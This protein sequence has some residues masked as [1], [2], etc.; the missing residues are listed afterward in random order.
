MMGKE[1]K[2]SEEGRNQDPSE[3]EVQRAREA[4]QKVI[5]TAQ[6]AL[7]GATDPLEICVGDL[8]KRISET[9]EL[10]KEKK[11]VDQGVYALHALTQI[12]D[13]QDETL[14]DRATGRRPDLQRGQIAKL[15]QEIALPSQRGLIGQYI[16][17]NSSLRA[18][19]KPLVVPSRS[20]VE[21]CLKRISKLVDWKSLGKHPSISA[22]GPDAVLHLVAEREPEF[23]LV[24]HQLMEEILA[25]SPPR[26]PLVKFILANTYQETLLRLECVSYLISSGIVTLENSRTAERPEAGRFVITPSRS[27]ETSVQPR[28]I[29]LG[30]TWEEWKA[31]RPLYKKASFDSRIETSCLG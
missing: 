14:Y 20:I 22:L 24:T 17:Q 2:S 19:S 16:A 6:A 7:V 10:A 31:L 28:T 30:L 21:S 13:K 4:R 11:D 8:T 5:Q 3:D 23:V 1:S 9:R 25:T 27:T 18:L 12:R 29:I 15:L 26:I